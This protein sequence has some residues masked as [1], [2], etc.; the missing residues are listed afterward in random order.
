MWPR[1]TGAGC[2][3]RRPAPWAPAAC[4]A[5]ATGPA[6]GTNYPAANAVWVVDDANYW[7]PRPATRNAFVSWPPPGYVPYP[8]VYPR[9]SFSYPSADFSAAT[10]TMTSNGVPVPVAQETPVPA[11]ARTRWCGAR[12]G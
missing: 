4:P 5:R 12:W 9:W 6:S 2:S 3:T 11:S 7:G 10:V 1:A 8:V